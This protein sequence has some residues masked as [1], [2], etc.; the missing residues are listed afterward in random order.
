MTRGTVKA[1]EAMIRANRRIE[2]LSDDPFAARIKNTAGDGFHYITYAGGRVL[3]CDTC[4]S[5]FGRDHCW[6]VDRVQD[7]LPGY[8]R[9]VQQVS[10]PEVIP[11]PRKTRPRSWREMYQEKKGHTAATAGPMTPMEGVEP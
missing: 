7:S 5:R 8:V 10:E 9:R 3:V 6:A 4:M 1:G 11:E 2:W